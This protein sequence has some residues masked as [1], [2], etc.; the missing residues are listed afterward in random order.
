MQHARDILPLIISKRNN[1]L[2]YQFCLNHCELVPNAHLLLFQFLV[3]T[4]KHATEVFSIKLQGRKS[5]PFNTTC[6]FVMA[7]L[8]V[9]SVSGISEFTEFVMVSL[10]SHTAGEHLML[11]IE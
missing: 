2:T 3:E 1:H 6:S 7:A 5:F 9:K 4:S 8:C 10:G 11:H